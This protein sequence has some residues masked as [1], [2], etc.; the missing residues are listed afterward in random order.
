MTCEFCGFSD[1]SVT[2]IWALDE[3]GFITVCLECLCGAMEAVPRAET[4]AEAAS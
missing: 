4:E 1:D 2:R 3:D